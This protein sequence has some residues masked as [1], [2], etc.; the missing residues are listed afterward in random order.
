MLEEWNNII[1]KYSKTYMYPENLGGRNEK[2][3][4]TPRKTG[5]AT[6]VLHHTRQERVIIKKSQNT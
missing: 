6:R 4:L 5:Y 3:S 1:N 2:K